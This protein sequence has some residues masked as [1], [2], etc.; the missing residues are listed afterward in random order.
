[1]LAGTKVKMSGS[2]KKSEQNHI[3]HFRELM[4]LRRRPQQRL[5]KK[6]IGLM[7]KTT[8]LQVHRAFNT[9]L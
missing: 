7:I 8:A 9:F 5:Q 1:M 6:T 3:Q 2:E 4:Q